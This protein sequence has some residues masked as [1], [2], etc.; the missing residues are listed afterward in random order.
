MYLENGYSYR[1]VAKKLG[2]PDGTNRL[3]IP[4]WVLQVAKTAD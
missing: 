1:V 4:K 2:I 3:C